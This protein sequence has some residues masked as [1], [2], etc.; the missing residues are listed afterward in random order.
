MQ[1]L[2]T[3]SLGT[4]S[5]WGEVK[6]KHPKPKETPAASAESGTRG[7]GRGSFEGRGRGR[8]G[9]ERGARG[10]R[11]SK[12]V[13]A[14]TNGTKKTDDWD[15]GASAQAAEAAAASWDTA[16]ANGDSTTANED[17]AN[18]PG[19]DSL[20]SLQT[21]EPKPASAAAPT[22]AKPGGW[23]GLFAKPAPA[24]K[25]APA[26]PPAAAQAPQIPIEPEQPVQ[27][28]VS[29]PTEPILP[30]PIEAAPSEGGPSE[31]PSAPHSETG[32]DLTPPK[33][34]LTEQNLE[35]LPDTSHPPASATAASTVASTQDPLASGTDSAKPPIRPG[36]SGYAATALKATSG[37]GRSASYARK[38]ME[39][40][41]AVVMPGHHA[42]EKA[43][44]QFGKLGL[45]NPDDLDVDDDR[46][47]PETRTQLPDDSPAAPRA[48]LPPS[49]PESHQAP[50]APPTQPVADIQASIGRQ[51]APGLPPVPQQ[52]SE[53]SP[54]SS[55][56]YTDQYRYGQGQ[57]PYD[58][59]GQQPPAAQPPTQSQ[60]PFS[61]QVPTQPGAA[62]A[63][64]NDYAAYYGRDAYNYYGAYGG[65]GHDA[66]RGGSTFGTSAPDAQGQYATS[67]PQQAVGQPDAP[68]SGNNTPAPTVPTH[69]AQHSG[70]VQQTQGHGYPGYGYPNAYSQQYPQ[71]GAS[72]MNQ[73]TPR[74]GTNRPMFDDVRRQDSDYYPSQ[75]NYAA[76]NHY[77]SGY[78][79]NMYAQ[80]QQG[81]SYDQASSPAA[82]NAFGREAGY[83]RSGSTQ[84][85][86]AQQTAA[87]STGFGGVP[88]PFGRTSSGF[89]Q[90][91]Q[92]VAHAAGGED[93][94]KAAGPSP[95]MQGGRPTSAINSFPA[96]GVLPPPSQHSGQQAFGGYPQYGGLGSAGGHQNTHQNTGYGGYGS[97]TGFGTYGGYGGGRGWNT[98]Y[99]SG[100]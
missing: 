37:A 89:G 74:Y 1:L 84:P 65:H 4:I 13:A 15:T 42:I 38:V 52:A 25:K 3:L 82:G 98:S 24:P 55:S 61:N 50:A 97:N 19:K 90:A 72:Y 68:G 49:L 44:V 76:Q 16:P 81:Y 43:A 5:Q 21:D 93:P 91:Q 27:E 7:R 11:G 40:Q 88:D 78:K 12:S 46:E 31:L 95:S 17:W 8:G 18:E 51:G 100:H 58:P 20:G 67:R 35:K 41:E 32:K 73:V 87:G 56:A 2:T 62:A 26:P 79:S 77:G 59:F 60:E 33:D 66:Q 6:K 34:E 85:S 14:H 92:H 28:S 83:G 75:Y 80:P 39:Q 45:G 71:Y 48:S 9:A 96:Q 29:A 47:E 10:G 63:A 86:E 53:P 30:P 64:Q 57:K 23:A 94:A 22:T 54:Q 69:Q 36:M 70:H 99:G